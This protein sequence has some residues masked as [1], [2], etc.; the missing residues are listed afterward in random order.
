MVLAIAFTVAGC[1]KEPTPEELIDR[2]QQALDENRLRAAE[3]DA[4]TALKLG[5][6]N[7]QARLMLGQVYS[8][9]GLHADAAVEY[10]KSLDENIDLHGVRTYYF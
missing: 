7:A 9:K 3:I 6:R 4:K 10:E 5:P 1:A 8:R 2:A